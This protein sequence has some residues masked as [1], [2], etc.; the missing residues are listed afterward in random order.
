M[1]DGLT[2]VLVAAAFTPPVVLVYLGLK[3]IV[4][5]AQATAHGRLREHWS[6]NKI[7]YRWIGAADAILVSLFLY[8][9]I[10]ETEWVELVQET[11]TVEANV[12]EPPLRIVHLS[13]LH[14]EIFGDRE[15]KALELVAAARPDLICL[16]GDYSSSSSL[17]DVSESRRCIR[18]LDAPH[19]VYAVLGN[20]DFNP[21][22]L[23]DGMRVQLL[24]DRFIDIE[25]RGVPVRLAG[26]RF[27][28]SPDSLGEPPA[29]SLNILL[30]HDPDHLEEASGLGYDLYLAGHTHGG[31]VRVPGLGAIIHM[32]KRG[33]DAGL[34]SLDT[35]RMYVNR[36]LGSETGPLPEVRLFCRPEVTVIEVDG[37][38]R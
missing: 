38:V 3:S 11:V 4:R 6:R 24:A 21:Q 15:R 35:T 20:W 30:H 5:L 23:F 27:G 34:Y 37:T 22:D 14:I 12:P 1:N 18:E 19:G 2:Y 9:W 31:Q 28:L 7:H 25:V 8:G 16:T 13:D 17:N 32:S 10:I 33:Y 29:D 36:G 26:V